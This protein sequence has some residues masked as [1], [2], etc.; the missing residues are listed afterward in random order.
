MNAENRHI[1]LPPP[2]PLEEN[3]LA[4]PCPPQRADTSASDINEGIATASGEKVT[5]VHRFN[6]RSRVA[7]QTCL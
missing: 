6:D 2:L 1:Y 7:G 3:P 4:L 5:D